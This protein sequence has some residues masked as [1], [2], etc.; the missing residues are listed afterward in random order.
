MKMSKVFLALFICLILI[1]TQSSIRN[2]KNSNLKSDRSLNRKVDPIPCGPNG[3]CT[4]GTCTNGFC[5]A[6][7]V[8]PIP[9]GP[10]GT[11]TTGTCTDGFCVARKVD[12]PIPCGPNGSCT[13]G[14]CDTEGFC[15]R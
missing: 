11:C 9:C 12:A 1:Q 15:S 4:T 2:Y 13:T 14:T 8:D 5:V 7:K 6:R 3:T 10:N